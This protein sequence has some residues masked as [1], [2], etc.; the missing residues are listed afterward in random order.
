MPVHRDEA[1]PSSSKR[2]A[3]EDADDR[4]A[5][6]SQKPSW[7]MD[8]KRDSENVAGALMSAKKKQPD[9]DS[10]NLNSQVR[11]RRVLPPRA[12]SKSHS[13]SLPS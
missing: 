3:E 10:R 12:V 4:V 1:A 9:R 11:G 2:K 8:M 5:K 7:F 6:R 13:V